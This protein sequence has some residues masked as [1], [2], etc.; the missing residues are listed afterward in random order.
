MDVKKSKI[1]ELQDEWDRLTKLG[2][3]DEANMVK[4]TIEKLKR[5]IS[6]NEEK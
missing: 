2:Q 1:K 5:E 4:V 3:Y 6:K